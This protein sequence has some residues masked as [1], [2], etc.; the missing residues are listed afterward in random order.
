MFYKGLREI[1]DMLHPEK[2]LKRDALVIGC[3]LSRVVM[4][5]GLLALAA[6]IV[7]VIWK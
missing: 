6:W 1:D 3:C 5:L 2:A 4:W 7:K